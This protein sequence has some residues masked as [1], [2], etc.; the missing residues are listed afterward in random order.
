MTFAVTGNTNAALF[1]AQP[2]VSP[3]GVLTYTSAPNASG[4]ATITLVLSDNGGVANGGVNQSAPVM[5]T[6]TVTAVND[7]PA[8]TNA[9]ITYAT[10]GNTQLHVAG[11]TRAGLASIADPQHALAKAV[12]IDIDTPLAGITVV[13]Q[14]GNTTSG[15]IILNADGTFSYVPNA[16]FIGTDTIPYQVTDGTTPVPG[17]IQITVTQRVWYVSNQLGPNN[18]A[19]G[20]GRST[21]AFETLTGAETASA[22][23]DI[24]FVFNGDS[25]TTPLG[26]ITLKNGVKLHGEGIGLTVGTFG[27]II[28]AGTAPRLTSAG[29]TIVVL[30]NMANGDRTGVE[31]R[32]LSL[33]STGGNAIDVT[34]ADTQALGVRISE[35]TITGAT[36]EGID[37][38][39]G[40]IGA[41]TLAVHDNTI[42]ATGTG[43]DITR[44][45]GTVTI[46]AFDDNVV[47]GATVGTGIVVAGPSVTFDATAGGAYQQVAGGTT[48]VGSIADPVGGA[49]IVLTNVSGDLAFTDLDI[50]TS[51][52]AGLLVIGTGAVNA[53]R[54]HRHTRLGRVGRGDAAVDWRPGGG[55]QQCHGQS[56][57][58]LGE[59]HE[60]PDDRHH[61]GERR[62][63]DD[64]RLGVGDVRIDCQHDRDLGQR[65]RRDRL[66]ELWRQ[67]HEG[68][69]L[70]D[71]LRQRW[72]HHRH[73]HVQRDVE[74]DERHRPESSTTPT[75]RTTSRARRR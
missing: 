60:Q 9:T 56:P 61:A 12:P 26:G 74:R 25:Q 7:A 31:I 63:G 45:A 64:D 46:T 43:L 3:A 1:S 4:S 28:P 55:C 33:A 70:R 23:N 16:G 41:A 18:A 44:T 22:A 8:L 54:R 71:G 57:A 11:A 6:I 40:S 37:I 51:N 20:D 73:D 47:S 50:F 24:I 67:H 58:R 27:T 52:G 36:A 42:T 19:G 21:D 35:N 32:G 5:F 17:S 14:N 48:A 49:G 53:A 68:E 30:A 13:P 59:R 38:N 29:N 66:A 2:A 72:A 75:A 65:R 62:V 10:A 39:H 34:S 15:H 69:Q